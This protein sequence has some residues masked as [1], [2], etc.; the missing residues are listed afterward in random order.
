MLLLHL[1]RRLPHQSLLPHLLSDYRRPA[2]SFAARW[3]SSGRLL[4]QLLQPSFPFHHREG[5]LLPVEV[6]P[7]YLLVPLHPLY[8]NCQF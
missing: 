7:T 5:V 1:Q 4:G 2:S 6:G 3:S 8:A